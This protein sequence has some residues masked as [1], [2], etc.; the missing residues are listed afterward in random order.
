MLSVSFDVSTLKA[1]NVDTPEALFDICDLAIFTVT[2]YFNLTKY[3]VNV[4]RSH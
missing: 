2:Y 3:F 4:M 1:C